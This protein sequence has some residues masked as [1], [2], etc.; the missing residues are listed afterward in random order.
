MAHFKCL[1]CKTR[2]HSTESQADPIGGLCPVHGSPFEPVGDLGDIVGKSR[3]VVSP[4]ERRGMNA[5][6]TRCQ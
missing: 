3:T 2:V 1:G 6:A 4:F 5:N